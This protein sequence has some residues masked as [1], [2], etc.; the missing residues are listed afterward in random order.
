MVMYAGQVAELGA[1]ATLFETPRHPYS[2]A[3]ARGVPF[4]PGREGRP[5]RHR[6]LPAESRSRPR[7][8]CR[9]QPRCADAMAECTVVDPPIYRVGGSDVRCLLYRQAEAGTGS[10]AGLG[11]ATGDGTALV[12]AGHQTV[13]PP[14]A[15][16]TEE[17]RAASASQSADD[18]KAELRSWRCPA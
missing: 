16:R 3:P 6:R 10:L 11:R 8:G 13:S 5:H 15:P 18:G 12:A 2:R 14:E 7:A 1:T 9:F 4:D 17:R